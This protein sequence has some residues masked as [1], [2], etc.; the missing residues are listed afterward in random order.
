[1]KGLRDADAMVRASCVDAAVRGHKARSRPD[2]TLVRRLRELARDRDRAVRAR[3]I[4]ALGVF[5]PAARIRAIDDPAAEVRAA[6]V[7]GA[8]ESELRV[9]AADRD[10]DVRASAITTLGDRSPELVTRAATDPAP[11]VRTAAIAGLGGRTV[12]DE[13]LERLTADDSP[14]VATAALVKLAARRGRTAI[15]TPFMARLAGAPPGGRARVRIALAW[16]LAR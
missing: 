8:S 7:S 6:S 3:A 10:P 12:D 1:M 9:L 13:L 11:Q 14:E 15:T 2:P 4:G 5:E 16:L